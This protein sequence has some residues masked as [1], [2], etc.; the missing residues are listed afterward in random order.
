MIGELW[1]LQRDRWTLLRP[2]TPK[3]SKGPRARAHATLVALPHEVLLTG[4]NTLGKPKRIGFSRL[5]VL[6]D[7]RWHLRRGDTLHPLRLE[8]GFLVRET[9]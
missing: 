4:G 7:G 3:G 9:R 6:R 8:R 2:A 1:S 5:W